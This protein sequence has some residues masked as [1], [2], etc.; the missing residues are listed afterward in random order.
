MNE[1]HMRLKI[2]IACEIPRAILSIAKPKAVTMMLPPMFCKV[3]PV[4]E[5]I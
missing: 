3:F 4:V 5:G 2:K 1:V